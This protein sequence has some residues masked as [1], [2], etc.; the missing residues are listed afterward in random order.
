[1]IRLLL[2]QGVP[3]SAAGFLSAS[4][5][6]AIHVADL[7]LGE[8]PDAQILERALTL[9]RDICTLDGDFHALMA[10]SGA[11]RPSVIFVCTQGLKGRAMADLSHGVCV[12]TQ[13]AIEAGA[14]VTV[15]AGRV[16]VRHLPVRLRT[17]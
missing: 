10:L 2:D 5:M 17:K 8:A 14:L 11:A 9:Q 1:M 4:G 6:D 7:R 16:R 15:A 3:Y 13:A 12:E